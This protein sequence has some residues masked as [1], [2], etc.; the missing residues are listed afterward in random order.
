MSYIGV[1]MESGWSNYIN[2]FIILGNGVCFGPVGKWISVCLTNLEQFYVM[3]STLLL[4]ILPICQDNVIQVANMDEVLS[5]I[6]ELQK[7]LD[8]SDSFECISENVLN[9]KPV[10]NDL[11]RMPSFTRKI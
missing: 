9:Y 10:C 11:N 6:S 3:F 5:E 1:N 8:G 4:Q 7:W 2:Y